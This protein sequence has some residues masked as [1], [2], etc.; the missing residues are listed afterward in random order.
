MMSPISQLKN[1]LY[2]SSGRKKNTLANFLVQT[3]T[4][5]KGI[6][7]QMKTRISVAYTAINIRSGFT[8]LVFFCRIFIASNTFSTLYPTLLNSASHLCTGH[9]ILVLKTMKIECC[10]SSVI[11]Q[12]LF[13]SFGSRCRETSFSINFCPLHTMDGCSQDG[14]TMEIGY[15]IQMMTSLTKIFQG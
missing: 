14:Q 11:T 7:T 8:L 4:Y 2:L 10:I 3:S 13:L 6:N 1:L 9:L 12:T 15:Y 5:S